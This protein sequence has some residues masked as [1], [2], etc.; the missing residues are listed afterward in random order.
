MYFWLWMG[1]CWPDRRKIYLFAGYQRLAMQG[2]KVKHDKYEFVP[3]ELFWTN[4][5]YG[6]I[7][8][9]IL[10]DTIRCKTIWLDIEYIVSNQQFGRDPKWWMYVDVPNAKVMAIKVG[11]VLTGNEILRLPHSWTHPDWRYSSYSMQWCL[12]ARYA[13]FR[14]TIQIDTK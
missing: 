9:S 11:K 6:G 1:R 4:K 14:H 13:I 8:L 10:W 3:N 7:K 2:G 5:S 12:T